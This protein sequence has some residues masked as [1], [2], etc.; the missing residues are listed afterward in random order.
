LWEQQQGRCVHGPAH[1][2]PMGVVWGWVCSLCQ[3][4]R[5]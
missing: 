5:G 2:L 3:T 4:D 1:W